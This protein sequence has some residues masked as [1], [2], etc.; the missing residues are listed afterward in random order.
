MTES[1]LISA[2]QLVITDTDRTLLTLWHKSA[3]ATD[4][5]TRKPFFIHNNPDFLAL[6]QVFSNSPLCQCREK[7]LNFL[8]HIYEENIFFLIIDRMR[9]LFVVH[10]LSKIKHNFISAIKEFLFSPVFWEKCFVFSPRSYKTTSSTLSYMRNQMCV[11]VFEIIAGQ[12]FAI[13]RIANNG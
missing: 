5:P 2:F 8:S 1:N 13:R 3:I 12:S 6:S 9:E 11:N 7:M 4:N 10:F